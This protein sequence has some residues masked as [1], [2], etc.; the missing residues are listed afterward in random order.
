MTIFVCNEKPKGRK[1]SMEAYG[2]ISALIELPF[3]RFHGPPYKKVF[4]N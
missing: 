1:Q 2:Q 3:L 4:V